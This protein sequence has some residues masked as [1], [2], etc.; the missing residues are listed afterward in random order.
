MGDIPLKCN[1]VQKSTDK[2]FANYPYEFKCLTREDGKT[3]A[4]P[5]LDAVVLP[6]YKDQQFE[7]TGKKNMVV[8][9]VKKKVKD[10]KTGKEKEIT[11]NTRIIADK[12]I[13]PS[14]YSYGFAFHS[15]SEGTTLFNPM[16]PSMVAVPTAWIKTP[17]NPKGYYKEGD[18]IKITNKDNKKHIYVRV[19]DTMNLRYNA[20]LRDEKEKIKEHYHIDLSPAAMKALCSHGYQ[21]FNNMSVDI[22]KV[23]PVEDQ[24]LDRGIFMVLP[25]QYVYADPAFEKVEDGGVVNDVYRTKF[26]GIIKEFQNFAEFVNGYLLVNN[27]VWRGF[28]RMELVIRD[29]KDGVK[30]LWIRISGV[31]PEDKLFYEQIFEAYKQENPRIGY[32]PYSGE[33]THSKWVPESSA[34]LLPKCDAGSCENLVGFKHLQNSS[35]KFA[36]SAASML[37]PKEKPQQA[38]PSFFLAENGKGFNKYED[39]AKDYDRIVAEF[40]GIEGA[41]FR[42]VNF[43]GN[44]CVQMTGI[45]EHMFDILYN[46]TNVSPQIVGVVRPAFVASNE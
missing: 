35:K 16:D 4:D 36:V 19:F 34:K 23:K 14:F 29:D 39:A 6:D 28:A 3:C 25:E 1:W 5:C 31:R 41:K 2:D 37:E 13:R 20:P 42:I 11:E 8:K 27:E 44:Y 45:S 30:K 26:D 12:E 21:N 46:D 9:T 43:G 18:W 7:F 15:T 40:G 33:R 22:Q 32:E 38:E 10:K 17:K 24:A